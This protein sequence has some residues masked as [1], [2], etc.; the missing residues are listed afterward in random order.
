MEAFITFIGF[1][2][3]FFLWKLFTG[4]DHDILLRPEE[5]YVKNQAQSS[6]KTLNKAGK[7]QSMS[8]LLS[9]YSDIQTLSDSIETPGS[10]PDFAL[11]QRRFSL[12]MSCAKHGNKDADELAVK[13]LRDMDN[14]GPTFLMGLMEVMPER[15]EIADLLRETDDGTIF[16]KEETEKV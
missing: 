10:K 4:Y 14:E 16:T 1:F 8:D 5:R 13:V 9:A 7:S 2:L 15:M 11:D 6:D 3:V 12:V